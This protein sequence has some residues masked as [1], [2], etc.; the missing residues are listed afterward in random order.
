MVT[1]DEIRRLAG[2]RAVLRLAPEAS[3]GP[4]LTGRILGILDAADGLVVTVEP[5]GVPGARVTVH[6]HYILGAAPA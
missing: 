4:S 3:V 6:Y 1:R 2:G 5:E